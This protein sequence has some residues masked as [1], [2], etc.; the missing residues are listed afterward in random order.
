MA[1]DADRIFVMNKGELVEQGTHDELMYRKGL[2]YH[3]YTVQS[4]KYIHNGNCDKK[5][6]KCIV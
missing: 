6:E 1:A 5:E 2:Y 4:S 3:M